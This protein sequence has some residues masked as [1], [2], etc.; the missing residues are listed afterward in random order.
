MGALLGASLLSL[1]LL[2]SGL[3]LANGLVG[4]SSRVGNTGVFTL[5]PSVSP[6]LI[7]GAG[8]SLLS[9]SP[10]APGWC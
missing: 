3:V 6:W 8:S 5:T 7:G 4:A 9:G 10:S 1:G 2:T